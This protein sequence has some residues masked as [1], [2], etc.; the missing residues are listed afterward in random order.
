MT[1]A[2]CADLEAWR[3][4]EQSA[5]LAAG[6]P[7]ALAAYAAGLH[8]PGQNAAYTRAGT[9]RLPRRVDH[10]L[11]RWGCVACNVCVT[12]RPNDAFFRLPTPDGMRWGQYL[13]FAELCN[14]CGNCMVFCPETGDPAAV[15]PALFLDPDRFSLGDRPGFLLTRDDGRVVVTPGPGFDQGVGRLSEILNAPEGLPVDPLDL[16][17][18]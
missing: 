8:D 17:P 16:V 3:A 11:E 9:A 7:G 15:K 18:A 13:F 4:H 10:V 1:S 14:Q 2:G 12:V 5:A 6:F